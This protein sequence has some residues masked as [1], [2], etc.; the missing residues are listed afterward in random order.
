MQSGM[1]GSVTMIAAVSPPGGD[2]SE[3]VTQNTKRFVR[4]FWQLDKYLA[5]AR[6]YPSINWIHSYSEYVDYVSAW[7]IKNI[8][9]DAITIRQDAYNLLLREEK[10][11][12]IVK[13]IGPDA[14][15]DSERLVL[16]VAHMLKEGFLK[17]NAYDDIDMYTVPKKQIAIL[18]LIILFYK[19]TESI[20][21]M[22][23]PIFEIRALQCFPMII[24]AR[25]DIKNDELDQFDKL[26]LLITDELNS[27]RLKYDRAIKGAN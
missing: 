6:H 10:L 2:F 3:P 26:S 4:A 25:L 27:L 5:S 9:V 15:P 20:I 11:Q 8:D 1:N 7:W 17:Q 21:Q 14:L 12:K 22:G 19:E 13:L 23:A 24:R 18:K 16:E